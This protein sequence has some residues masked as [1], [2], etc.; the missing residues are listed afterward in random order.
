MAL[1]PSFRRA[2]HDGSR[3]ERQSQGN[4]GPG[5]WDWRGGGKRAM[6]S[7]FPRLGE[8][9]RCLTGKALAFQGNMLGSATCSTF[10]TKQH[11]LGDRN[12]ENV[13]YYNYGCWKSEI[14]VQV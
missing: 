13:F 5:E 14:K 8:T 7:T 9:K 2:E 11:R 3:T 12:D 10:I 1:R 4:E 6:L